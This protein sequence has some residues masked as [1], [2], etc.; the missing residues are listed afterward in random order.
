MKL[1]AARE[2]ATTI[3]KDP[4]GEPWH[5]SASGNVMSV[6]IKVRAQ[7][8]HLDGNA[9]PHF[10]ITGEVYNPRSRRRNG[11]GTITCG[12]IH[13]LI[14]HYWPELADMVAVHL[15]DDTGAPMH[16]AANASYFMG[17]SKYAGYDVATLA[18]HLRVTESKANDIAQWVFNFYGDSPDA[19]DSITTPTMAAQ[20]AIEHFD[21]AEMWREQIAQVM[22][23]LNP[24][25]VAV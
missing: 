23:R 17:L 24:V 9:R 22:A 20:A 1:L 6:V 11:D 5:V 3:Y 16:A 25:P 21:L 7:L 10:S 18:R 8:I 14:V 19:Y 13:D 15:S 12:C 4:N 2:W